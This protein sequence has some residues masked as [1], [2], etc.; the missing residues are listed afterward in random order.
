LHFKDLKHSEKGLAILA[1]LFIGGDYAELIGNKTSIIVN[2]MSLITFG[3]IILIY[4]LFVLRIRNA[5]KV[6][7]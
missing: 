1:Y 7:D 2:D 3:P 6:D 5:L 4:L